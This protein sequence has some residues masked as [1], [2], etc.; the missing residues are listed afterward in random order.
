MKDVFL[1]RSERE[2]YIIPLLMR[3]TR[4]HVVIKA[5]IL[6]ISAKGLRCLS[7]DRRMMLT[8]EDALYDKTFRLEFDF[9]DVDTR[10]LEGRVVDVRPGKRPQYERKLGVAFTNIAPIPARD[11]NRVV[12]ADAADGPKGPGRRS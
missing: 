9:R 10:E 8:P 2:P 7:N 11:I 4:S 1:R 5:V 12:V 6:D 3:D